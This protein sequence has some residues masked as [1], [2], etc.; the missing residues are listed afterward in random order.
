VQGNVL[1]FLPPFLLTREHVDK[2]ID[3]LAPLLGAA[4]P[5]SRT[6]ATEVTLNSLEHA[7][8]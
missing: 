8:V 6:R 3:V 7:A 5:G 1:R 4:A 2:A